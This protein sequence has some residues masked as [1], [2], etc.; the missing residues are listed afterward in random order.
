MGK[1]LSK[2]KLKKQKELE[3]Q[4]KCRTALEKAKLE[5]KKSDLGSTKRLGIDRLDSYLSVSLSGRRSIRP[6]SEFKSKSY[7]LGRQVKSLIDHCFVR[8]EVPLFLYRAVL[9]RKGVTTLFEA[10]SREELWR[11][12]GKRRYIHWF[13]TVA[14]GGSLAAEL[15]WTH[16]KKE[17][18][19]FLQ[20][21][22]TNGIGQNLFWAKLAAAGL[23]LDACQYLTNSLGTKH[24]IRLFG[25][26]LA[27]VVR[28]Y[29]NE[30]SKMRL[31][32]RQEITEFVRAQAA[33]KSFSFKGR[34]Y[35]SMRKL[36]EEWHN[37]IYSS[38]VKVFRT[39]PQTY[40][41]WIHE[42]KEHNIRVVE[43]CNSRAL[44]DEGRRQKN[45][46]YSY[47][48]DCLKNWSRILSMQWYVDASPSMVLNRLTLEVD[49]SDRRV[50]QIRGRC[51]RKADEHEMKVVRLWA[52]RH[53][54]RIADWAND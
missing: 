8:Y 46:A 35:G 6:T 32:D 7:N 27:D 3:C 34:T 31:R 18:H 43:L 33:D 29:A 25:N 41:P 11:E 1:K 52:E 10:P 37:S 13:M 21:P 20:A 19:W 4:L 49:P 36:T 17:V 50:T 2:I 38:T 15:K 22:A 42:K 24:L 53:N 48:S 5:S 26:R 45:C 14:Q 30:W 16:S 47:E 23:P 39:W 28:F 54:H 51:N 9:S 40:E 44:A 12:C